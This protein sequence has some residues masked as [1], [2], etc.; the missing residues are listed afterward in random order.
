MAIY[1]RELVKKLDRDRP[2]W[3]LNTVI[4]MDNA[5][6]HVSNETI[7]I[8]KAHQVPIMFLGPHS[9]NVAP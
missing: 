2:E 1:L 3:R 4:T 8:L 6:Y 9:Y 7:E 5:P